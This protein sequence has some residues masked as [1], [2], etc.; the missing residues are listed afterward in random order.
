MRSFVA[1]SLSDEAKA[2]FAPLQRALPVGRLVSPDN[3]HLTLA[4][5]D[6]QPEETLEELHEEFLTLSAPPF[7]FNFSGIESFGPVLA[8]GVADCP[9]LIALHRKVQSAVRR[10]GIVLP[11][12][13]FHPHVTIAR[14]KPEHR[15]AV[16]DVQLPNTTSALPEMLVTGFTLYQSTLRPEGARHDA[17]A[18]YDLM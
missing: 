1:I 15:E 9:A 7:E 11:R 12:R 5:L 6:N 16:Q 13:R 8:V 17:L 2:A 3:M 18:H 10:A 14:L 4:F